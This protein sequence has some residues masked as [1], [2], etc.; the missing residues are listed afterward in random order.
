[1]GVKEASLET[2]RER[3]HTLTDQ[4]S[5]MFQQS[6]QSIMM[7]T[8]AVARQEEIKRY[9][10]SNKNKPNSGALKA[11][12][13]LRTD[14]LS[15]L[16]QLWNK[17]RV[18]VLSSGVPGLSLSINL[19]SAFSTPSLLHDS[20]VVGKMYAIRDIIYY[21]IIAAVTDETQITGYIISWKR[22]HATQ[23]ALDQFYG[24][25]GT[26]SKLYFGNIDGGFWT[27]LI[28]VV[29]APPIAKTDINKIKEYTTNGANPVMAT[30]LPIANTSWLIVVEFSKQ[31]VLETANR[32][33]YKIIIIGAILVIIG[34]FIAAS[35]SQNITKP[36]HKLTAAA[37]AIT[38]GDYSAS[39]EIERKDELG[40]LA[41]AFNTMTSQV[42]SA[43]FDLE[44]KVH[45]RTTELEKVKEAAERAN[46]SKT[47]FLSSMSHEIRT[48]LN[49]ILG[50]T[51]ILS[52]TSLSKEQ[53]QEYL[54]H[55][56]TAGELL[57]KLIGDILDLNK[58]EEGKLSLENE[59]F[60]FK[61]FVESSLYPYKFQINENGID[62]ILEIDDSIP[63]YIIS[64]RHRIHQLLVNLIG[65]SVKFTKEGQVGIKIAGEKIDEGNFMI[66]MSVYDTGI[67]IPPDKFG[68]IF[69]SF[70]QANETISRNYGGS[71]LGLAI[72]KHLVT[73][74][75]G[76]IKVKSPFPHKYSKGDA[77]SCF[78]IALPVKIDT[79]RK[80]HPAEE[81]HIN[82]INNL[83]GKNVSVLVVDDNIMNQK[84]ASFLLEKLGCKIH[85]AGDGEEA[86]ELVKTNK[87]DV[88]LMDVHMPV[89]DGYE[90]SQI[91]RKQLRLETPIIGVTANVFKD[92][93]EKCIQA[94]MNDHLGKPYGENQLAAKINK[95]VMA[96]VTN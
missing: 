89:M 35:M 29:P 78:E 40:K 6:A 86:L 15:V 67:G 45:E 54:M 79:A 72:V 90:A 8:R 14:S 31:K 4:L 96:D 53:E 9:L 19:D 82:G 41:L 33:L 12:E 68:K 94:G 2:G 51:E 1:M 70:T 71:G 42:R 10:Q 7:T 59:S 83:E 22:V 84:L 36:L 27:N 73:V 38:E 16:V 61:E 50:F 13:K 65:N 20:A 64:D 85:V 47:R 62:F 66:R 69:E 57:S 95:W 3:L 11:L 87:I 48:P 77:G 23:Q 52:K 92:D 43:Q 32:F 18:N 76:T 25:M 46:Q 55:I 37:S 26:Q 58:I 80:H 24:L 91:I 21:P 88:I 39:V 56:K 34:I 44:E 81:T 5:S 74:M 60:H 75:N 93:I 49:G 30:I 63:D 28:K 17:N